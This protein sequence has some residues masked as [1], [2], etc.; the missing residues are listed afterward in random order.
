MKRECILFCSD[1]LHFSIS[2]KDIEKC[3][4]IV[5]S[6]NGRGYLHGNNGINTVYLHRWIMGAGPGEQVDHRDRNR[7]NN[8]DWNLRLCTQSQN[9]AAKPPTRANTSGYK[10]VTWL[11]DQECWRASIKVKGKYYYIGNFKDPVLAATAYDKWAKEI[12]GDFAYLNFP[13]M[14]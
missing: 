14:V 10:G 7:R 1:G 2:E 13:E 12:W 8:C 9:E 3:N 5:W 6:D 11:K 4:Y